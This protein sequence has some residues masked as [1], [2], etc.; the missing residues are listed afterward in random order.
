MG[1]FIDMHC[2]CLPGIDDGA[3][4]MEDSLQML[5]T[6]YA[7]GIRKV[8]VTPHFHHRRGHVPKEVILQ[9]LEE[10]K[11]E[12]RGVCP[13]LELYPGN[14]LHYSSKLPELLAEEQVCTMANSRYVLIEFS[15]E[16][17]F[18]EMRNALINV[19]SQGVWPILAHIERY[20][21]LVNKP[22]LAEELAEMGIY[23][24]VNADGVLG[25][26]GRKEKKLIKKMFSYDL[27][28]FVASDAHDTEHRKQQLSEAA[29]YVRKKFGEETVEN[30]FWRNQQMVIDNKII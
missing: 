1:H 11:K 20:T 27:I 5:Q 6:A 24:Q 28:S 19:Q 17:E 9:K 15:P 25:N 23:L 12:L 8:I 26:Y 4:T 3:A 30:C 22:Q 18:A 2:H 16:K 7:D 10:V 14:E 29:E 13:D 21:C